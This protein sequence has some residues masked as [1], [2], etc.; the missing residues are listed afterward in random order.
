MYCLVDIIAYSG[1]RIYAP[2]G[3]EVTLITDGPQCLF[4]YKGQRF[5]CLR[6]KLGERPA[7]EKKETKP[8]SLDL[9]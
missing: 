4:E 8:D 9:F 5:Y 2:K 3:G 7:G 6:E 1:G